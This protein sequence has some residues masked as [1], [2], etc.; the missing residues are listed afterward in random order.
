MAGTRGERI[1]VDSARSFS[2]E[3]AEK[4]KVGVFESRHLPGPDA[5]KV[6]LKG[7]AYKQYAFGSRKPGILRT[8]RPKQFEP[9]G[10]DGTKGE[11]LTDVQAERLLALVISKQRQDPTAA[12]FG[13]L[14]ETFGAVGNYE[15]AQYVFDLA[16]K[17][18]IQPT[19]SLYTSLMNAYSKGG[20]LPKTLEIFQA[21]RENTPGNSGH[22]Y[23]IL[24]HAYA[25][26]NRMVDAF[27]VID[28]MKQK[29]P[30][31]YIIYTSLIKACIKV[32]DFEK[33]W[34]AYKMMRKDGIKPNALTYGVLISAA[35]RGNVEKAIDLF[36]EMVSSGIA[37]DYKIT[38]SL[39]SALS[40]S[41]GY[42]ETGRELLRKLIDQRGFKPTAYTFGI[43]L[44][45]AHVRRDLADAR[46]WFSQFLT[47]ESDAASKQVLLRTLFFVYNRAFGMD[48]VERFLDLDGSPEDRATAS[49]LTG[50]APTC[51]EDCVK[52]AIQLEAAFRREYC[53]GGADV[54]E[55]TRGAF[56]T[57]FINYNYHT[58]ATKIFDAHYRNREKPVYPSIY[59]NLLSQCER[60]GK[61]EVFYS[62]L[63]EVKGLL[64]P[65]T[66]DSTLPPRERV[67]YRHKAGLSQ[68]RVYDLHQR[69]I[70]GLVRFNDVPQALAFFEQ[71]AQL[72]WAKLKVE[73]P[74]FK[75]FY[76]AI[77]E[78]GD[79]G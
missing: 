40:S 4:G 38:H 17:S 42:N 12:V 23:N 65:I 37:P 10:L 36:N 6:Q 60:L 14:I 70:A 79:S 15:R 8:T 31:N 78:T 28:L 56:L 52:E 59:A 26:N 30:P 49:L 3:A 21:I 13:Q 73:D 55:R 53:S 51:I 64:A 7:V 22:P 46:L 74:H 18:G 76:K 54:E 57:I 20:N 72:I 75:P 34:L 39:L 27:E 19:E 29:M 50:D 33:A 68:E 9:E 43:M 45:R 61:R 58:E 25:Q 2:N 48:R 1:W 71:L 77:G 44:K 41:E 24:I 32:R 69:I 66:K 35:Q 67:E 16:M 5:E 47:I 11:D 63:E 62:L